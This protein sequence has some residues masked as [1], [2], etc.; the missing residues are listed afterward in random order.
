MNPYAQPCLS[1]AEV[2]ALDKKKKA[3]AKSA[4]KAKAQR[5]ETAKRATEA[6]RKREETNK[7]GIL[8]WV[9]RR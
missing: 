6:A 7:G 4:L 8:N 1:D 2:A 9:A 3:A 5:D